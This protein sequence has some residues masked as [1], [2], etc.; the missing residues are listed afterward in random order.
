[1]IKRNVAMLTLLA[2]IWDCWDLFDEF[3]TRFVP[4]NEHTSLEPELFAF[5]FF[6]LIKDVLLLL[7]G[8]TTANIV[9]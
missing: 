3:Q 7:H 1:M 2:V 9:H 4:A 8:D 5:F 6:L